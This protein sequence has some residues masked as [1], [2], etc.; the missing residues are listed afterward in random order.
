MQ[1]QPG[2][3]VPGIVGAVAKTQAGL[4][5]LLGCTAYPL[6]YRHVAQYNG[7]EMKKNSKS[8]QARVI[9][10][11]VGV[12]IIS[13]VAGISFWKVMQ[14]PPQPGSAVMLTLPEPRV[15]ADFALI[16]DEGQP[17]S[18]NRLQ[19]QWSLLFFGFTHCPDI[20]PSALYDLSVIRDSLLEEHPDKADQLQVLFVSVDPERDTPAKL[21]SYVEY[22]D[23]AFIGVTGPDA[24]LAPLTL[25]LGVAYRIEEHEEGNLAYNVDHSASILLVNPEGRLHGVFPAPHSSEPMTAELAR[26]IN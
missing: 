8:S 14:G 24:Q 5:Q 20:C 15:V 11:A 26:V 16:D 10:L 7:L 18:L 1:H 12:G 21:K 3:L 19:G 9:L 4:L 22:F 25:Q 13:A 23:P 17:F 6:G 2:C